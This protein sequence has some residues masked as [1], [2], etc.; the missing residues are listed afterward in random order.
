MSRH[1]LANGGAV[2]NSRD[3]LW[4]SGDAY[5]AYMGR[6]SR[7]IAPRFLEWLRAPAAAEWIDIGCGTGVLSSAIVAGCSPSRVIGIDA[8]EPFIERARAY[9]V[10]PRFQCRQGSGEA[11]P[12]EDGTFDVAVSALVLNFMRDP[13]QAV[14]EMKRVVAPHGGVGLYVWDYAGHMQIMRYF[15]DAA[16]AL[17]PGARQFDDGVQAPICRPAPLASAFRE[18]GL[19]NVE[20]EAIDIPVAF[21]SFEDYWAP[22][23]GGTGSAPKYCSSLAPDAQSRL[24]ENLRKVLPT[25]PDG[26]ILIAARAWAVKGEAVK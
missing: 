23:L 11:L 14:A 20:V 25:G 12:H 22:F 15:F 10:D 4:G 7:R 19:S 5:E 13:T 9:I 21:Q 6:W 2:A 24:R 16:T 8:S 1:F 3:G 17:D 18:A 26:E